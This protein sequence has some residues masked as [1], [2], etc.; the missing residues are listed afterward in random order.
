LSCNI[1]VKSVLFAELGALVIKNLNK[2]KLFSSI[3]KNNV[4]MLP[5]ALMFIVLFVFSSTIPY[6]MG[7]SLN[8]VKLIPINEKPYGRSY[9]EHIINYWKFILPINVTDNPAEDPTGN[10]CTQGQNLSTSSIFYLHANDGG[11]SVKTCIMPA[12]KGLFIPILQAESSTAEEPGASIEKLHQTVKKD[13]DRANALSLSIN[14]KSYNFTELK[15]FREATKD[16]QVIFPKDPLFSGK[17]GLA[18]SVS[19][20]YQV[21]TSPLT[22]GNYT[23]K[24]KGSTQCIG[25]EDPDCVNFSS[26]NTYH[27]IVR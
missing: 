12:G 21:I 3:L 11:E 27:L 6:S 5:I 2:K 16:F 25:T 7:K 8:S 17:P 4:S 19:D 14:D 9:E 13:Q 24:F 20:G 18:T 15:K 10:R 1:R 23:I 22:P 26:D